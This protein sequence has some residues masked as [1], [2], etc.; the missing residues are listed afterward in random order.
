MTT[1]AAE[2]K[3]FLKELRAIQR[4]ESDIEADKIKLLRASG[5]TYSSAYPDCHWRWSRMIGD[6]FITTADA[7][8]ALRLQER[9]SPCDENCNHED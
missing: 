8:E 6:R 5:W 4:L 2:H 3:T 9:I 7:D 1:E